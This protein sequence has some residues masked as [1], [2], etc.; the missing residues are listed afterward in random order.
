MFRSGSLHAFQEF[1]DLLLGCMP[2][3][4]SLSVRCY[5]GILVYRDQTALNMHY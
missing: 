5:C 2:V 1:V 3:F 4:D